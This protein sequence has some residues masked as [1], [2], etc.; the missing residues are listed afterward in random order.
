MGSLEFVDIDRLLLHEEVIHGL[1]ESVTAELR[2]TG[3]LLHPVVVSREHGIVLDGN[4]RVEALRRIGARRVLAYKVDYLSGEV[5]VKRWFRAV[6]RDLNVA[7]FLTRASLAL[8]VE[9]L[10]VGSE[11]VLD[12]MAA[13]G[14][15]IASVVDASGSAYLLRSG[16]PI[17]TYQAYRMM[18][19]I[20][21]ML[22][23]YGLLHEREDAALSSLVRGECRAVVASRPILKEDVI[24]SALRGLT[25]PPKSSRHVV[26][27]RVLF[28]MV[29]LEVLLSED[30]AVSWAFLER[31][32]GL[33]AVTLPAGSTVDRFY[34]EEVRVLVHGP[35]MHA[36]YPQH[37]RPLL[38]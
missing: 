1:L 20:D 23:P 26:R 25:F 30:D 3:I 27:G 29:P 5:E 33:R 19:V 6:R 2:S 31:L 16:S 36:L 4:H 10:R 8:N 14:R 35:E 9:V 13:D 11:R 34:E 38:G 15:A 32:R 7:E 24:D 21:R 18:A 37:I 28:A 12:E 22:E 17:T